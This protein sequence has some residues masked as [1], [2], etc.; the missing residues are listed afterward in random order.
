MNLWAKNFEGKTWKSSSSTDIQEQVVGFEG[1][2]SL[3]TGQRIEKM[4]D[5]DLFGICNSGQ[6]GLSIPDGQFTEVLGKLTELMLGER[7]PEFSRTVDQ[8]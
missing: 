5:R 1:P 3:A 7:E 8:V 6:I 2:Q 4:L